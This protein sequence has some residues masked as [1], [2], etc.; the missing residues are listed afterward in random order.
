V[1]LMVILP[2]MAASVKDNKGSE[3]PEIKA[4]MANLLMCLKLI[5]MLT[6]LVHNNKMDT[7]FDLETLFRQGVYSL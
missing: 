7:H 1:A 4:G 6:I 2:T 3:I 5:S